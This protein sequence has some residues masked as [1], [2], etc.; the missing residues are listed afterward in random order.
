MVK[1]CISKACS[2]TRKVIREGEEEGEKLGE[3]PITLYLPRNVG[4]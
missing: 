1:R 3:E 2:K 4:S